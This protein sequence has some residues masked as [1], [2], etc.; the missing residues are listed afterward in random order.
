MERYAE[1][2]TAETGIPVVISNLSEHTGLTLGGLAEELES[3]EVR[4]AA[5]SNADIILVAIAHNS[6]MFLPEYAASVTPENAS[7]T[8]EGRR[9]ELEGIYRRVAE[10]RAGKPTALRTIN[11]YNDSTTSE[12]AASVAESAHLTF[13]AWNNVLCEAAMASGFLCAD[14]YAAFNGADG[15]TPAGNLLAGDYT[16]PSDLGNQRIADVLTQLGYSPLR[17]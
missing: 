16:H 5:L 13:S 6:V 4:I 17:P 12:T 14:V 15:L 9:A 10:L 11:R 2:I 7:A 8:A 3:D 1:Q